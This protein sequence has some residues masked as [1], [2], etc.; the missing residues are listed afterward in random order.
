MLTTVVLIVVVGAYCYWLG[1]INGKIS[2][3]EDIRRQVIEYNNGLKVK[4]SDLK[5]Q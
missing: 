5:P 3:Y 2:A 1:N 4:V